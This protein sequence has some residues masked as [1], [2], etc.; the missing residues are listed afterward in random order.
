MWFGNGWLTNLT[1][2]TPGNLDTDFCT[3]AWRRI[4]GV[5]IREIRV[6]LTQR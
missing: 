4:G 3:D 6:V 5:L 2:E 1:F